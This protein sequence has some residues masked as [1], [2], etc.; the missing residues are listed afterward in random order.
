MVTWLEAHLALEPSVPNVHSNLWGVAYNRGSYSSWNL[1]QLVYDGQFENVFM[2]T[3]RIH[4]R[5]FLVKLHFTAKNNR[6]SRYH[7]KFEKQPSGE[8]PSFD[9][10]K[11]LYIWISLDM[12]E[13][14]ASHELLWEQVVRA[15]KKYGLVGW[16]W[17][18][19]NRLEAGY[20]YGCVWEG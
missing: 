14:S 10:I 3:N 17:H 7:L 4:S 5:R 13:V 18:A 19:S 20:I 15:V 8:S 12:G 9:S 2:W 11:W 1:V 6:I 16:C